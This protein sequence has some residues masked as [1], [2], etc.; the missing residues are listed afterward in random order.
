MVDC[1]HQLAVIGKVQ[2]VLPC[3]R[4]RLKIELPFEYLRCLSDIEVRTVGRVQEQQLRIWQLFLKEIESDS[5]NVAELK[6]C[7]ETE[8]AFSPAA[9]CAYLEKLGDA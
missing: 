7:L 3:K 6:W 9:L 2:S 8:E 1:L 4:D 5:D